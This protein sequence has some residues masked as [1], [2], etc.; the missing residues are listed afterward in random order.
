MATYFDSELAVAIAPRALTFARLSR[1][2]CF[3]M[4][5]DIGTTK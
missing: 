4:W 3:V 1:A 2:N 5:R